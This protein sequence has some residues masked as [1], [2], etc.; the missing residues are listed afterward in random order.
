MSDDNDNGEGFDEFKG[1]PDPSEGGITTNEMIMGLGF[2]LIIA[3]FILGLIR[4]MGLKD[5]EIPAD[6]E[7]HLDQLY[8]SYIIMFV[9]MMITSFLGFGGMFKRAMTSFISSEE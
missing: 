5:G 1:R 7:S 2:V 4:L 8:L 9:G 6:F 3:G